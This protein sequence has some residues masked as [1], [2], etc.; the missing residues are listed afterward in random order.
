[1]TWVYVG[2]VGACVGSMTCNNILCV[3]RNRK[4]PAQTQLL[5]VGESRARTVTSVHF[6]RPPINAVALG[7]TEKG[8]LDKSRYIL[9]VDCA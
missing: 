7:N 9:L 1:M 5:D 4:M 3:I 6:M 2:W 8:L